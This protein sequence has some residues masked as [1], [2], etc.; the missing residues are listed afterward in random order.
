LTEEKR[1]L[2]E[3]QKKSQIVDEARFVEELKAV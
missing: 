2:V 3:E 1:L